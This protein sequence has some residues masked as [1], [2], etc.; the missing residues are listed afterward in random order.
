M[1][2]TRLADSLPVNAMSNS[3]LAFFLSTVCLQGGIDQ[4]RL[5]VGTVSSLEKMSSNQHLH[6]AQ[7]ALCGGGDYQLEGS[8]SEHD[9]LTHLTSGQNGETQSGHHCKSSVTY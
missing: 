8:D 1:K 6:L 3:L 2:W 5:Q 7:P 9:L 4:N